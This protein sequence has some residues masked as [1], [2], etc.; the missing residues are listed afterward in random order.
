MSVVGEPVFEQGDG[1]ARRV[2]SHPMVYLWPITLSVM[3]SNV[4]DW[5]RSVL[6]EKHI[7]WIIEQLRRQSHSRVSHYCLVPLGSYLL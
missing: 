4:K 6:L 5:L 1:D 2:W 7:L 3:V